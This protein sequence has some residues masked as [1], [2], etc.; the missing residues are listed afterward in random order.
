MAQDVKLRT[1][2]T[3]Q[4]I[5]FKTNFKY[6]F[7]VRPFIK[8][9]PLFFLPCCA[10]GVPTVSVTCWWAGVDYADCTEKCPSVESTLRGRRLPP[11]KCT[12]C[13]AVFQGILASTMLSF[14]FFNYLNKIVRKTNHIIGGTAK[15]V[16]QTLM[17][18]GYCY[19][20]DRCLFCCTNIT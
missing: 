3:N 7:T 14:Y 17:P 19:T 2:K 6:I 5:F 4:R 10:R 12:L 13:W 8:Y 20:R 1:T 11:V 9:Y 18:P 16:F 15:Q